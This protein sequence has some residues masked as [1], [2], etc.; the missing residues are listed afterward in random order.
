MHEIPLLF[1]SYVCHCDVMKW[2][3]FTRYWHFVRGNSP[4]TGEFPTQRPVT[5][6]FDILFGLR[7]NKRLSEQS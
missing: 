6:S 3:H 2:K 1:A 4:I 5:R 7:L